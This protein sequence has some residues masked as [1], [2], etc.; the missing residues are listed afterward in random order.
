MSE[1]PKPL[2]EK[3]WSE[4]TAW[5][6]VGRV[7]FCIVFIPVGIALA[8]LVPGLLWAFIYWLAGAK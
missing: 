3:P 5:E 7:V 4:L 8:G 2:F 6:R 1:P